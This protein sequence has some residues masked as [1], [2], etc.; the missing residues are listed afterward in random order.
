VWKSRSCVVLPEILPC[1]TVEGKYMLEGG[2]GAAV[3]AL[4]VSDASQGHGYLFVLP[5]RKH[6]G[7]CDCYVTVTCLPH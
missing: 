7:S 2:D 5:F 4:V 3:S 1:P 6:G